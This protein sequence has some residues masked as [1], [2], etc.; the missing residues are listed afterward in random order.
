M[1]HGEAVQGDAN[2]R[3]ESALAWMLKGHAMVSIARS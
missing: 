2:E 3:L 1:A